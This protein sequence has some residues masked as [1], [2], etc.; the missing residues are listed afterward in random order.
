[1]LA[2]PTVFFRQIECSISAHKAATAWGPC[3]AMHFRCSAKSRRN[4]AHKTSASCSWGLDV[5]NLATSQVGGR[6]DDAP[7]RK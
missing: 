2:P 1:M 3:E 6:S 7:A 4:C 5:V